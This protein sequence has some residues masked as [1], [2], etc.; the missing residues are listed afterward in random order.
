MDAGELEKPNARKYT[1]VTDT[2]WKP[3]EG[4]KPLY[5]GKMGNP[6]PRNSDCI[7][8]SGKKRKRCCQ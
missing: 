4:Q 5:T 6:V 2:K 1:I 7:C 8:G 3:E